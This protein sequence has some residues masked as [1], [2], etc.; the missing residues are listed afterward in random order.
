MSSGGSADLISAGGSPFSTGGFSSATCGFFSVVS[1]F[2]E[3][4][5]AGAF[6]AN[7]NPAPLFPVALPVDV[8]LVS[9]LAGSLSLPVD[10][11]VDVFADEAAGGFVLVAAAPGRL[12]GGF[13]G[14]VLDVGGVVFVAG[15]ALG[16]GFAAVADLLPVVVAGLGVG[17]VV[18][19]GAALSPVGAAG[20]AVRLADGAGLLQKLAGT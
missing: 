2:G 11:A 9:G 16:E 12:G 4:L 20:P 15:A 14:L 6:V 10:L 7:F 17:L 13:A 5:A 8:F 18:F 19:A 3:L 1:C